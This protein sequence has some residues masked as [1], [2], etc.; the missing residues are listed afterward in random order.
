MKLSELFT[1]EAPANND[2]AKAI[3]GLLGFNHLYEAA[4]HLDAVSTDY[5]IEI[6]K[7]TANKRLKEII[8]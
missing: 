4:K 5:E 6:A 7:N 8:E 1:E 2:F 3:K